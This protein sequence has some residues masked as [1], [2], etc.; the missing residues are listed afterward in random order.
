MRDAAAVLDDVA[1]LK[2]VLTEH[3]GVPATV[4]DLDTN[5]LCIALRFNEIHYF[6]DLADFKAEDIMNLY[7]EAF[8]EEFDD[9]HRR[10]IRL[11]QPAVDVPS[12]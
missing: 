4:H 11:N 7:V 9:G 12:I 3:C 8:E 10:I 1:Q 6:S 5:P 2:W